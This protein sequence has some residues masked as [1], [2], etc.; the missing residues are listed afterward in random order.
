MQ[1]LVRIIIL[2]WLVGITN[3]NVLAADNT[4]Q[5]QRW[6]VVSQQESFQANTGPMQGRVRVG[7]FQLWVLQLHD[8]NGKPVYPARISIDGGMPGHGHGLPTRPQI[9]KYLGAGRWQIEGL[10]LNMA[11]DWV[12]VFGIQTENTSD[13]VKFAFTVEY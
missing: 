5:T 7:K 2:C 10:K 8:R 4:E 1:H 13:L 12:L 3:D 9:T 6:Q 11:G